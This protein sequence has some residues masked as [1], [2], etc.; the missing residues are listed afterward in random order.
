MTPYQAMVVGKDC[1]CFGRSI[2]LE[3]WKNHCSNNFGLVAASNVVELAPRDV[4]DHVTVF[5]GKFDKM[6]R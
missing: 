3:S 2:I 6:R 5:H 4:I 1:V